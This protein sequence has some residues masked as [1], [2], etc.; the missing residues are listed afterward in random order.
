MTDQLKKDAFRF[1][2]KY[3]IYLP[4]EKEVHEQ[5]GEELGGLLAKAMNTGIDKTAEEIA[6]QLSEKLKL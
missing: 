3:S 1:L 6:K 2:D 4:R 5:F